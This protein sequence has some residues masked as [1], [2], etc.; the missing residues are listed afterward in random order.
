VSESNYREVHYIQNIDLNRNCKT[1][2]LLVWSQLIHSVV[3]ETSVRPLNFT[4]H[5]IYLFPEL[6]S[7]VKQSLSLN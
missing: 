5:C 3:W 1:S 6:Q 4:G 7:S 2:L